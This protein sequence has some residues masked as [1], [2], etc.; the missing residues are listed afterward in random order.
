MSSDDLIM[1]DS[2]TDI[3]LAEIRLARAE[4][5]YR[6]KFNHFEGG[7]QRGGTP[8]IVKRKME[9]DIECVVN[10]L[11]DNCKEIGLT[12]CNQWNC[13]SLYAKVRNLE[14][15]IEGLKIHNTHCE[16]MDP[17][18]W[19][20]TFHLRTDPKVYGTLYYFMQDEPNDLSSDP[21]DFYKCHWKLFD[22]AAERDAYVY[23]ENE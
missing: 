11:C 5:S 17:C 10:S 18:R 8:L 4:P 6:A 2:L 20:I 15:F 19:K 23:D 7:V 3:I 1:G 14:P 22:S 16:S 13:P 9:W 12:C 21:Y